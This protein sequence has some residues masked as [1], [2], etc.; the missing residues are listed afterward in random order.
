MFLLPLVLIL[1][2]PALADAVPL[3][4]GDHTIT[5]NH[6]GRERSVIVHVPQRAAERPP[7][8]SVVLNFHDGGGHG[9]QQKEYSL[10]DALADRENFLAVYPNGTGR[11]SGR[12]LTWNAALAALTR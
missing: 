2:A 5:L 8:L 9:A 4:A 7:P 12:L 1:T 6:D 11:L 3:T 10:L